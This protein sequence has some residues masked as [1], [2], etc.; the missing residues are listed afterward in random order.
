M[1]RGYIIFCSHFG[2]S[3]FVRHFSSLLFEVADVGGY[4]D[5]WKILEL[6]R[7]VSVQILESLVPVD[8]CIIVFPE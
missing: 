1:D 4:L 5:D 8:L 6:L 7:S 2:P 3:T